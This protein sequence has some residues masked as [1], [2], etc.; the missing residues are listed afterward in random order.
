MIAKFN[1][2]KQSRKY[3]MDP[4]KP[5]VVN[6][7]CE[8]CGMEDKDGKTLWD[9]DTGKYVVRRKKCRSPACPGKRVVPKD[10][11]LEYVSISGLFANR[12]PLLYPSEEC[13]KTDT[14]PGESL[15]PSGISS[16]STKQN[17]SVQSLE[18]RAR[19]SGF[20]EQVVPKTPKDTGMDVSLQ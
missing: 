11:S 9:R 4:T 16:V 14:S 8:L 18:Y 15:K 1:E 12:S 3:K 10:L 2:T 17:P 6:L 13:Q 20:N 7:Q 19:I 5:A